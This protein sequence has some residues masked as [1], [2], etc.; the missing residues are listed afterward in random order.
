[1]TNKEWL[2]SLSSIELAKRL[3]DDLCHF[4]AFQEDLSPTCRGKSCVNGV[5]EWLNSERPEKRKEFTESEL[6][7]EFEIQFCGRRAISLDEAKK[8]VREIFK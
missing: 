8:I 3:Y 2:T 7:K 1:M 4:C 5:F 6:C